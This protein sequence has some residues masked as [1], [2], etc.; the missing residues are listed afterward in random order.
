MPRIDYQR[1]SNIPN[2]D[3]TNDDIWDFSPYEI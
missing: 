1:I 2:L 3:D